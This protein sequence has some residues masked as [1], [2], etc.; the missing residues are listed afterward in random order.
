MANLDFPGGDPRRPDGRPMRRRGGAVYPDLGGGGAANGD[1]I[2]C[3]DFFSA[4][5]TGNQPSPN[6]EDDW[7]VSA[8]AD[9]ILESGQRERWVDVAN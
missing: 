3:S 8:I 5:A 2:E 1:I 6:F 9:A 7:R 4:I